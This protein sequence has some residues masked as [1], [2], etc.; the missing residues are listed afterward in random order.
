MGYNLIEVKS[1]NITGD[2]YS[3]FIVE[4]IDYSQLQGR[5]VGYYQ[6]NS[7]FL[8]DKTIGTLRA[9]EVLSEY[10]YDSA[11]INFISFKS[12]IFV[13]QNSNFITHSKQV[14]GSK[15]CVRLKVKD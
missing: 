1:I 10:F 7:R 4:M 12:V 13:Q 2:S 11:H 5:V 14:N 8:K 3:Y 9:A 6:F 15:T